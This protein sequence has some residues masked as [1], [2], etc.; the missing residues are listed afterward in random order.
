MPPYPCNSWLRCL[1]YG[2]LVPPADAISADEPRP[3][4]PSQEGR[5][6]T[7][8]PVPWDATQRVPT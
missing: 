4:C 3:G 6:N 8:T 7:T 5:A 2:A 1:R